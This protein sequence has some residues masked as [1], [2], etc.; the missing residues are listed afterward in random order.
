MKSWIRDR[1]RQPGGT[2]YFPNLA[3]RGHP[4]PNCRSPDGVTDL[5]SWPR[6]YREGYKMRKMSMLPLAAVLALSGALAFPAE[7][8]T[9]SYAATLKS[10]AEAPP[11]D[12]KGEPPPAPL[13]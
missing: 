8:A 11:N 9:V 2:R 5:S 3:C 1:A 10:S 4:S 13:K 12:S 7:A 6:C